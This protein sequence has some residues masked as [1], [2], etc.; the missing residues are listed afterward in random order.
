MEI[1][2]LGIEELRVWEL[3]IEELDVKELR[4]EGLRI[5]RVSSGFLGVDLMART[6]F[7]GDENS[8]VGV[9]AIARSKVGLA[10]S[11]VDRGLGFRAVVLSAIGSDLGCRGCVG[12]SWA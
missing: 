6:S 10:V 12:A 2:G 3:G 7:L 8:G 4:V 1:G 5:G 9:M 11:T